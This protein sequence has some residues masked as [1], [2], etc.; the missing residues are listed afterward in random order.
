MG[1]RGGRAERVRYPVSSSD[2]TAR[3]HTLPAG[4]AHM[5]IVYDV[6]SRIQRTKYASFIQV[7]DGIRDLFNAATVLMNMDPRERWVAHVGSGYI[8]G[9][10]R[11]GNAADLAPTEE[12]DL[13][14]LERHGHGLKCGPLEW[15]SWEA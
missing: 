1:G 13:G 14:V 11:V 6:V 5:G 15:S 12:P 9:D 3:I 4:N 8:A 10:R 2:I 7:P